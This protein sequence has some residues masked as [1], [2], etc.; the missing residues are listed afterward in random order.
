MDSQAPN[1]QTHPA[2][3]AALKAAV[4]AGVCALALDCL[5]TPERLVIGNELSII[6]NESLALLEY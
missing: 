5:V 4:K 6:S 3:G 2:F 1:H